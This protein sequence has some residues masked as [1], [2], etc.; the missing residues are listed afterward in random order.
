MTRVRAAGGRPRGH[1][2]GVP[3]GRQRGPEGRR[4]VQVGGDG[5]RLKPGGHAVP[6][7]APEGTRVRGR[8]GM[9]A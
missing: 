5:K 8:Q 3:R 6:L 2:R 7:A 4:R 9:C 1:L